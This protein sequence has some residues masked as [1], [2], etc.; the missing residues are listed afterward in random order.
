MLLA[1][2]MSFSKFTY[3][4][5]FRFQTVTHA[6]EKLYFRKEEAAQA[7]LRRPRFLNVE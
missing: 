2:T 7:L 6:C 4:L 3:V 1:A 5:M